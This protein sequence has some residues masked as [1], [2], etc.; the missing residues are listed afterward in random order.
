MCSA[1]AA[2][3]RVQHE[4]V[5]VMISCYIVSVKRDHKP[6][7]DLLKAAL[8][9]AKQGLAVF[10][11]HNPIFDEA[12]K[13]TGCTCEEWKR[14]Q[15]EYSSDFKCDQPGKCPRVQWSQKSTTDKATIRKWWGKPWR[16]V[17]VE[18]GRVVWSMPNIGLDM[19]KSGLIAF[20]LDAYKENYA[21]DTLHLDDNTITTRTGGGGHHLLYLQPEGKSYSNATGDLP[22]GVD[23]RGAGGYTVA[24]PSLHLSGKRYEFIEGRSPVDLSPLPLPQALIDILDAAQ[25]RKGVTVAFVGGVPPMPDLDVWRLAVDVVTLICEGAPKGERSEADFK[26]ILALAAAG[27]SN[28]DIYGVFFHHAI[29]EKFHERGDRYLSH[30]I[31]KARAWLADHP[32]APPAT[33]AK[34]AA[35]RAWVL[36]PAG[37][38]HLRGAGQRRGLGEQA[39]F[40]DALLKVAETRRT[41][42]VQTTVRDLADLCNLNSTTC[43]RRLD[44]AEQAGLVGIHHND[45]GTLI[46]LAPLLA[47]PDPSETGSQSLLNVNTVSV[48]S[49]LEIDFLDEHRADDCFA[50][51]P[52]RFAIKRRAMPTVLLQ[53]LGA[54]G[55]L[56]WNA[57]AAGGTV[58]ELAAATG[59]SVP[60]VRCTLKRFKAAGLLFAYQVGR[61]IVYEAHPN[62]EERLEERRPEMVTAGIGALRA[63][64]HASAR[65][66]FAHRR[67]TREP[68]LEPRERARL[69]ARRE[70]W[71]ALA[72]AHIASLQARG[73]NAFAKVQAPR[74]PRLRLRFDPRSEWDN[75]GRSLWRAYQALGD[76]DHHGKVRRLTMANLSPD[77]D[78]AT[79]GAA[80][81]H[82]R[83]RVKMA[84]TLAKRC[85]SLERWTMDTGE[86]Q[87]PVL[88]MPTVAPSLFSLFGV[89]A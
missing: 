36:S 75:W 76:G 81:R 70:R 48:R 88:V 47:H 3:Q 28:D 73:I 64:R 40:L 79:F 14:T 24:P 27:A 12:G 83:D 60:S 34:V 86:E 59:L 74:P 52:Y 10:P 8:W 1:E 16:N 30:S 80:L 55:L 2:V 82:M 69:Q 77:A 22:A 41:Q 56:L 38:D 31:G 39:I 89:A 5:K 20:D 65:A 66:D 84:L 18:T 6:A 46:D 62:I 33:V 72:D 9:H 37:L 50:S 42:H 85:G 57:L 17:D 71:D 58:R 54:N 44:R 19:G 67:L 43:W 78:A 7:P 68:A 29:G 53:S 15:P 13:C 51:Y 63:A 25:R 11:L 45:F 35:A 32:P 23:V 26:V 21:G 49:R 4:K 61:A 87:A